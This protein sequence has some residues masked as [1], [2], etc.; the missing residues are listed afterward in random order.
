[1]RALLCGIVAAW[2]GV[3]GHLGDAALAPLGHLLK[4]LG[5]EVTVTV[6]GLDLRWPP[7]WYQWL[8]HRTLPS[9]DRIVC[10]SH[11]TAAHA[12]HCG[13]SPERISVIPPGVWDD[14]RSQKSDGRWKLQDTGS[15]LLTVGRLTPR[16]GH[17]WFLREVFPRLLHQFQ[18][19]QYLIIGSGPEENLIKKIVQDRR[20]GS[21]VHLLGSVPDRE[22]DK[23]YASADLFVMP[24]LARKNDMEGFGLVCIEASA[25][26]LPVAAARL[27]GVCDA[28]RE[29]ETG[30]F[31]EPGNAADCV[32]V[33]TEMLHAPLPRNRVS[34]VTLEHF[35]WQCLARRYREEV[36]TAT[37]QDKR[38]GLVTWDFDPPKG[39]LGRALQWLCTALQSQ[40]EVAIP[41]PHTGL[42]PWT[43]HFGG[44]V[45]FSLLLP[46]VLSRFVAREK[47]DLLL[48]PGGPGGVFLCLKPRR[49]R[50]IALVYHT[51]VQ[52][53]RAVPLQFWKWLFVPFERRSY[54]RAS[55]VVCFSRDTHT[56]L[57][58]EYGIPEDRLALLPQLFPVHEWT[59]DNPSEK[60]TGLCVCVA[61]LE[62]R[63]GIEVL[64]RAWPQIRENIP[65]ATLVIIGGG[66]LHRFVARICRKLPSVRLISS[67]P[68]DELRA[69]VY[70]AEIAICPSYLEGFGLAAAEAMAAGTTVVACDVDGLRSLIRHGVTGWLVPAGDPQALVDAV[71]FLLRDRSVRE[72]LAQTARDAM[73]RRFDPGRAQGELQR[74]LLSVC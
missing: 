13:V 10:I 54:S 41:S 48:F 25:H 58:K 44:H 50:S 68:Q 69:L 63:K 65:G 14:S 57:L 67:L 74:T 30:R 17:T 61:R 21:R 15:V 5:A 29:G 36:F 28:V 72:M 24:N 35:N 1:M 38:I 33:I 9:L 12:M 23:L 27:E 11:A 62:A 55:S 52:Q 42:L 49:C 6:Y 71:T 51:Y 46:F 53:A 60:E 70:K 66:V 2:R 73:R 8:L 56:T 26:G 7:P 59:G 19:I 47:I 37:R 4:R 34:C 39:G 31:F 20:L 16:K 22:R 64:L 45:L 40:G 43:R 18:D 3:H 32:R